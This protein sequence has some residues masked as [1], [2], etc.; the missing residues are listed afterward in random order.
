MSDSL[1]ISATEKINIIELLDRFG[2]AIDSRDWNTF[3]SLFAEKVEFDYSAI[4]DIA[5]VFSPAE[6][7]NNAQKNFAGFEVTQHVITNHQIKRSGN[8]ASCKAYVRA[9]HVLPNEEVEPMLEIGGC[10]LAELIQTDSNWKIESWKFE[11]FWSKG[12]FALFDLAKKK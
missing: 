5:G 1:S 12:D 6:I 11:L 3:C 7:T 9:M 8:T 10:Y 2:I 4:G